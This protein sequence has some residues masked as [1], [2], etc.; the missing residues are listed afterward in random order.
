MR[1][2]TIL[3][4]FPVI[5]TK[6]CWIIFLYY[7]KKVLFVK[8][9]KKERNFVKLVFCLSKGAGKITSISDSEYFGEVWLESK[10]LHFALR[11]ENHS[12][13]GVLYEFVNQNEYTSLVKVLNEKFAPD[14][15]LKVVDAGGNIGL[16]SILCMQ[17]FPK[18]NVAYIEPDMA[19]SKHFGKLIKMNDLPLPF[20]FNY[21]LANESGNNI[22]L[23]QGPRGPENAGFV[24]SKTSIS[25]GLISIN[26]PKI[27]SETG[28]SEIDVLK[29]DIEGAEED[30]ILGDNFNIELAKKI[31]IIAIEIHDEQVSRV[32][33]ESKLHSLNF[34][35]L[36]SSRVDIFINKN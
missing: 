13:V 2:I 11:D 6:G 18:S 19:A 1:L 3:R 15:A 33:I 10:K 30:V 26:L 22:L 27:M 20:I 25:T 23:Q 35:K 36:D 24:T 29:I 9:I 5:T 8:N 21:G 16:F 7:L 31:R 17:A 12:D 4:L 32:K 34:E 14:K 28:F